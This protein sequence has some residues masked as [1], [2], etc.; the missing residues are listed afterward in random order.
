VCEGIEYLLMNVLL[1]WRSLLLISFW[2]N[3]NF[4]QSSKGTLLAGLG[5]LSAMYP[6][7]AR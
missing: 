1:K 7:L 6:V 5:S 3:S 2:N 4:H